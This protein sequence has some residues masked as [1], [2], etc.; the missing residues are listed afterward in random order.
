MATTIKLKLEK[1]AKKSGGDRYVEAETN[2]PT[3]FTIYVPQHIS[4]PD[5]VAKQELTIEFK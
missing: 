4:R 2:S 5:G 3:P 1:P